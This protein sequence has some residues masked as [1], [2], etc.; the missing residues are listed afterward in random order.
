MRKMILIPALALSAGLI[1]SELAQAQP[2]VRPYPYGPVGV[3]VR[4]VGPGPYIGI[5]APG[6]G[7]SIGAPVAT[8]PILR[9]PTVIVDPAPVVV[10]DEYIVEYRNRIGEPWRVYRGYASRRHA[11]DVADQ[12]RDMGYHTRILRD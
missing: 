4:P 12:L 5:R 7:I 6:V 1:L 2:Y 8:Y 11:F 3:Y 9:S 10:S